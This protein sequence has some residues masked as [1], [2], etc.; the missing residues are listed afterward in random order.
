MSNQ[1]D[2]DLQAVNVTTVIVLLVILA[3]SFPKI[4]RLVLRNNEKV[5]YLDK[6]LWGGLPSGHLYLLWLRALPKSTLQ[7]H[8]KFGGYSDTRLQNLHAFAMWPSGVS[9][10]SRLVPI[11][12]FNG[13][14]I[15]QGEVRV[16]RDIVQLV[17]VR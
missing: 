2:R 6:W 16:D 5:V 9:T 7:D 14:R 10:N 3:P 11:V 15:E 4:P 1:G 17:T 12:K 13:K 8:K